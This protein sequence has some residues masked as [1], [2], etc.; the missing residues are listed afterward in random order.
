MV[1]V[2][3]KVGTCCNIHF[4]KFG[5]LLLVLFSLSITKSRNNKIPQILLY[6]LLTNFQ[7]NLCYPGITWYK[8]TFWKLNKKKYTHSSIIGIVHGPLGVVVG[9]GGRWEASPSTNS[10]K[11]K[12]ILT[13]CLQVRLRFVF[14]LLKSLLHF[15]FIVFTHFVFLS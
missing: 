7:G 1:A 9:V 11:R 8:C 12:I 10:I 3:W 5:G 13:N 14:D 4:E 15:F 6:K 2:V